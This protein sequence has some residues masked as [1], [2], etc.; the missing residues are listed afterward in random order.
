MMKGQN[1]TTALI[2][3]LLGAI[4]VFGVCIPIIYNGTYGELYTGDLIS[5][6]TVLGSTE[7]YFVM[8]DCIPIRDDTTWFTVTNVT[9]N[10]DYTSEF[11]IG[12]AT[13]GNLTWTNTTIHT[14]QF[15]FDFDYRCTTGSSAYITDSTARNITSYLAVML[16]VLILVGLAS[17]M[18][19]KK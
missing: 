19:F 6:N 8:D 10:Q 12:D 9:G 1:V 17:M 3:V 15:D 18:Y 14:G 7:Q 11:T 13:T 16:V 2:S 5:N 4:L